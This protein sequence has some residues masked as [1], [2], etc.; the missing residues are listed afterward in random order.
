MTMM[1]H[2][3]LDDSSFHFYSL[4]CSS[5]VG[6]LVMSCLSMQLELAYHYYYYESLSALLDSSFF[7]LL[8]L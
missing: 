5:R 6:D 3:V 7:F 1:I 2:L 8:L 4:D